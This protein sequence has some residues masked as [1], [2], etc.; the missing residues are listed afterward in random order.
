MPPDSGARERD[1]AVLRLS[2]LGDVEL[3]EHFETRRDP[4]RHLLR[5]P[6]HLAQDAVHTEPDCER[7]LQRFEVDVRG[8]LLGCL[9]DEGV[10]EPHQRPVRDAVV[11]LEVVGGRVLLVHLDGDD[12]ADG[13]G[14]A[15]K[16]LQ[17]GD[18]VVARRDAEVERMLRRQTQLVDRV[19]IARVRDGNPEDVVLD[20]VRNGDRAL[21]GL[22]G[23]Q[24]NRIDGNADARE[25]D[26]G[27]VVAHRQHPGDA[28]G[29]RDTLVDQRLGHRRAARS[30]PADLGDGSR[31][32]EGRRLQQIEQELGCLVDAERR[33]ERARRG[34][35]C[36]GPVR[37]RLRS[38][39]V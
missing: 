22:H 5:N 4:G 20:G 21:Q 2:P 18:D 11:R 31:A 25:V 8:I 12:G 32:D 3:R 30:A 1:P 24:L 19:Q 37:S 29:R 13:L 26:D 33:R 38:V 35:P 10:D 27:K 6:L 7:V 15:C 14:R 28:L 9:E 23:D 36:P 17:L 16:P 34:A 39:R